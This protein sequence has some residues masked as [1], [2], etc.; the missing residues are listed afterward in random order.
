[1]FGDYG[2]GSAVLGIRPDGMAETEAHY[3]FDITSDE[4]AETYEELRAEWLRVVSGRLA[5]SR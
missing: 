5:V 4:A 1:L 2:T 3:G